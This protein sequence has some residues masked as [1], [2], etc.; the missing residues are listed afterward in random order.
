MQ[1]ALLLL[2]A[3]VDFKIDVDG[4]YFIEPLNFVTLPSLSL[5]CALKITEIECELLLDIKMLLDYENGDR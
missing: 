2:A 5:K 3:A 4:K 1:D